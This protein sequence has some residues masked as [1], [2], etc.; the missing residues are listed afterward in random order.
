[1]F[2]SD[3]T[4]PSN[5]NYEKRLE[6][7]RLLLEDANIVIIGAG[8]GFSTRA[9]YRLDRE[10]F[11]KHFADFEEKYGIESL[12][13]G[14]D[15]PFKTDEEYWAYWSRYIKLVRYGDSPSP[16]YDNLYK[17]IKDKDY[18]VVTTNA[19]HSFQRANFDRDRLFYI[20]GDY[21]LLQCS[22]PCH[23]KTYDNEGL[24]EE[25][26]RRQKDMKIPSDLIPH[27]PKCGKKMILSLR[28][29]ENFVEDH[30][31]HQAIKRYSDFTRSR[32]EKRS[33]F[34][35]LGANLHTHSIIRRSFLQQIK[36]N[37]DARYICMNAE[38]LYVDKIMKDKS[39][40]FKED[41]GKVL[42]D[43]LKD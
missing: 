1:M 20:Q 41:M 30:G 15:Y 32:I 22:E 4:N 5:E 6:V 24:I 28:N 23:H 37:S 13:E 10:V 8:I 11:Y 21:G 31:W 42:E 38:E 7:L 34:I 27:C 17:L 39:I 19:N 2:L 35:E 16:L 26:V 18:F 43:L 9:G 36:E 25:M 40:F 33:L 3:M 12:D 14:S 29:D